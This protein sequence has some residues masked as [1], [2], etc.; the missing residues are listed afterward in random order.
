MTADPGRRVITHPA[1]SQMD[2]IIQGAWS[3]IWKGA[4]VLWCWMDIGHH[5]PGLSVWGNRQ[6]VEEECR[7][8][9]ERM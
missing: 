4:A 8:A 3:A 6:D 5:P 9:W 7:A 1:P 2:S